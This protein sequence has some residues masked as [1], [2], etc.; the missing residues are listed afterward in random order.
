[1]SKFTVLDAIKEFTSKLNIKKNMQKNANQYRDMYAEMGVNIDKLGCIMMDVDG[2]TIQNNINADDLYTSTNKDRHWINGFVAGKTPHVTL[3]YGLLESGNTTYKKYVDEV[4]KG[5]QMDS[6]EVDHVDYF[7]SPFAD[8]P[9]YCI[10]AHLDISEELKDANNRLQ[11]LP[12]INTFPGYK[13]HITIAYIKK[14]ETLRDN[15]IGYYNG[16]LMG[17]ELKAKAINYG[18]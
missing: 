10:V 11:L 4:L 14:D 1:M 13:A 5:W 7:D 8:D 3:L 18:K 6:V 12:H 16:I 15:V 17:K 9:Y 2:S